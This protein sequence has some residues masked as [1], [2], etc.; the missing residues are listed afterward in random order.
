PRTSQCGSLGVGAPVSLCIHD[1]CALCTSVHPCARVRPWHPVPLQ[2]LVPQEAAGVGARLLRL[3]ALLPTPLLRVLQLCGRGGSLLLEPGLGCPQTPASP[4]GWGPQRHRAGGQ[5]VEKEEAEAELGHP[6]VPEGPASAPPGPPGSLSH[7]SWGPQELVAGLGTHGSEDKPLSGSEPKPCVQPF[8]SE[9]AASATGSS[10]G[11]WRPGCPDF[12]TMEDEQEDGLLGQLSDSAEDLSLDLGALQGSEYLQDLGLGAFSHSQPGEARDSG[13]PSEEAGG[14]SPFSSS[15]ESQGGPR[16]RSW[17][18]SRSCSESWQRLSLQAAA[19]NEGPCLPRTLASLALNLP[20]EDLQAWTQQCLSG[21]ATPAE[22]PGKECDS[23]EKR[24]RSRSVPVSFD[25]I[26]S[27]EISPALEVPTPAVQGLEPPVLECME[28]DHVEPDHVLIVQKV[29]QELRQYHGARQRA[30]LSV[31]PGEAHSNLTWFEFLSESEDSASKIERSDRS[32]RVKRR[33]SSLRC[34]VTRQ[35][36]KGKSPAQPKDKG[37]D[38]R[39]RKECIHGHQL[40]QGTFVGHSSCPLC[41]KPFLS[42]GES[43]GPA[44]PSG[45]QPVS[46]LYCL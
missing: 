46:Q 31:T 6:A 32:T 40:A 14:D 9:A 15:A 36:E 25:E 41:G 30:R 24:V 23:P 10:G 29:L 39:E 34:R 37:Q 4:Q 5:A 42:S 7:G 28:K 8:D 45:W 16:R 21:G 26:S 27:L 43:G 12:P 20:G 17:E 3:P 19:V 11:P 38:A 33:L 18:R 44:K 22:H 1:P 2:H 13:P 35:K